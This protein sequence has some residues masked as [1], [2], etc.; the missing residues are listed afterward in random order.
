[1][2]SSFLARHYEAESIPLYLLPTLQ[3][4]YEGL[5]RSTHFALMDNACREYLFVRDF[6]SLTPATAQDFFDSIFGKT[7]AFLLVSDLW[8]DV[9]LYY[10]YSEP[11]EVI[12]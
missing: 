7:L 6:F 8:C 5:F 2:V 1:M 3:F 11:M 4:P 10:L 12:M 9:M